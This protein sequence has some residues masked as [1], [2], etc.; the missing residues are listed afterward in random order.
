MQKVTAG[1]KVIAV[2]SIAAIVVIAVLKETKKAPHMFVLN[3]KYHIGNIVVGAAAT[4][5]V[6]GMGALYVWRIHSSL[7]AGRVWTGRRITAVQLAGARAVIMLCVT[8]A[9]T[10]VN[11]VV[12]ADP[13]ALCKAR[14]VAWLGAVRWVGWNCVLLAMIIDAHGLVPRRG[15]G[16]RIDGAVRDL[17]CR[18]HWKKL[19]L[20]ACL[21]GAL[22]CSGLARQVALGVHWKKLI[23]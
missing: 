19:L 5:S 13:G 8:S 18:V 22:S 10:A 21:T 1:L 4:A 2:A 7:R 6:L 11:A 23:L 16:G 20:W 9:Y 15:A 12:L 17:P 14:A 3:K